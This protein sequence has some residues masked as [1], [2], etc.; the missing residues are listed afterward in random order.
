MSND[1][2]KNK[3]IAASQSFNEEEVRLVDEVFK[4]VLAGNDVK[5]LLRSPAANLVMRKFQSMRARIEK[6]KGEKANGNKMGA[7]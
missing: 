5:Q 2:Y 7:D 4:K 6:M 3:R 1:N